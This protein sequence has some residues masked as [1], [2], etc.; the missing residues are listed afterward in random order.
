MHIQRTF[1]WRWFFS[2]L[3]SRRS[4]SVV[5]SREPFSWWMAD[6]AN[7]WSVQR[8]CGTSPLT[9]SFTLTDTSMRCIVTVWVFFF[10]PGWPP[11]CGGNAV[12]R[13]ITSELHY[14]E[15]RAGKSHTELQKW[16]HTLDCWVYLVFLNDVLSFSDVDSLQYQWMHQKP[17][18]DGRCRKR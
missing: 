5:T 1:R 2:S 11:R 3:W 18:G 13:W 4:A 16:S 8:R 10:Y 7:R 12:H 6:T 14:Q 17:Q 15:N 9:A